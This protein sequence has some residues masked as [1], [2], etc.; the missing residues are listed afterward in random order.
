MTVGRPTAVKSTTMRMRAVSQ[1]K[2]LLQQLITKKLS[3]K[4]KKRFQNPS[5]SLSQL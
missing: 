1:R 3:R 4:K 5:P 2:L